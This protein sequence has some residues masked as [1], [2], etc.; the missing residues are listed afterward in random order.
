MAKRFAFMVGLLNRLRR[1]KPEAQTSTTAPD[2]AAPNDAAV[3][4]LANQETPQDNAQ[5]KS[6][7]WFIDDV[8]LVFGMRWSPIS[9]DASLSTQLKQ[10]RRT[11]YAYHAISQQGSTL[12]LALIGSV[13]GSAH[14]T[15]LVL[16][17]HFST[18]GAELFVFENEGQFA[19]I[20]LAD[21]NP[22]PG[23][24]AH[25]SRE[26][27]EALAEEFMAM[28]TGQ[29]IRLVGNVDWLPDMVDL[30]PSLVA[31]RANRRS[32][33]RIIQNTTLKITLIVMT[34]LILS[35]LGIA[36]Y[37][38]EIGWRQRQESQSAKKDA[39]VLY[40][41]T[42]VA[43]LT[44]VGPSGNSSL[45]PWRDVLKTVPMEVA[46]WEL[47][48]LQCKANKCLASWARVNGN[49]AEF[50]GNFPYV[51]EQRPKMSPAEKIEQFLETEHP[52]A[53]ASPKPPAS[54]ST[55]AVQ[56]L[57]RA[58]LPLLR[59]AY[60]QWGSFILDSQLLPQQT[61][62]LRPAALFGSDAP[63]GEIRKPVLKGSW[64]LE[65]DLWTLKD[66]RLPHYVVAESLTVTRSGTSTGGGNFGALVAPNLGYRYKIEGSF[67][68]KTR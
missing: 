26:E 27:I 24:D 57:E 31:E 1:R 37:Q 3:A 20:G 34:L 12:G 51:N 46:G 35:G 39:N 33:L 38:L 50:D 25:G 5:P 6:K 9:Q 7:T 29:S 52:V 17:E 58:N 10:A 19:L 28:N 61:A 42:I 64:Q 11:G 59:D 54:T 18:S 48:T 2:A 60:L 8:R 45:S 65:S 13:L 62:S 56:K 53:M 66:L 63:I 16:A 21:N 43:N 47:K 32:R 14:S 22:T 68:A 40:E 30:Q 36:Y 4:V 41:E 44:D 49:F 15:A 23:F 67:Y 55:A